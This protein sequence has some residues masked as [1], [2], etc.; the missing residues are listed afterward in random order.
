M[1]DD[2][3]SGMPGK[4]S[5]SLLFSDSILAVTDTTTKRVTFDVDEE[6]MIESPSCV[7]MLQMERKGQAGEKRRRMNE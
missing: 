7:L 6:R 4:S 3:V 5:S 2:S 1:F